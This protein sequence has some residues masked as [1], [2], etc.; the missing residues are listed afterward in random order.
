M[1]W[2]LFSFSFFF[3]NIC[4]YLLFQVLRAKDDF[5]FIKLFDKIRNKIFTDR[6]FSFHEHYLNL[7]RISPKPFKLDTW[8]T[9]INLTL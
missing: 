4:V 2:T 6:F 9:K 3:F 1:H 8:K 7:V 5:I